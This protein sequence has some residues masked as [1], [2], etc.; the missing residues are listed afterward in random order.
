[1]KKIGVIGIILCLL[2]SAYSF[3]SYRQTLAQTTDTAQ[4]LRDAFNATEGEVEGYSIHNWSVIDQEFHS[5]DQLKAMAQQL[6]RTFGIE[7]AKATGGSEGDQHSVTL[8]GTWK[9]GADAQLTLKSMRMTDHA[10]QTALVL[11]VER[12]TQ[13]LQDY[14]PSIDRVRATAESLHA[15]PQISTCVKGFLPDKMENGDSNSLVKRVF[16]KVK[17]KEIEGVRSGLVTSVSGFSPLS[18]D[19]IVT[20]G[21]KMNVQ[22]AVHYDA[23]Q[24]KTRV[25]VGSPIVT[26]EY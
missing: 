7:N 5:A 11:R 24:G 8:R 21:N 25:L 20:N 22:V 26:I 4:F 19:Y 23:Y 1:M 6:N 2:I 16:E 10:P 13:D 12:E 3:M 17:A 14:G 18:R 15:V 9:N